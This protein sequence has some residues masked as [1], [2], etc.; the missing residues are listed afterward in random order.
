[1]RPER[2]HIQPAILLCQLITVLRDQYL[3]PAEGLNKVNG[4]PFKIAEI[5]AALRARLEA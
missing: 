1:M 2:G 4:K 5:E 3:V